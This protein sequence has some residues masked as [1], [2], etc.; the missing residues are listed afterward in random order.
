MAGRLVRSDFGLAASCHDTKVN[1]GFD[2]NGLFILLL[3]RSYLLWIVSITSITGAA[4]QS[5]DPGDR[6][7]SRKITRPA[8]GTLHFR[9]GRGLL[10]PSI[11]RQS[12]SNFNEEVPVWRQ[13]LLGHNIFQLHFAL[14]S[15]FFF[16]F[17]F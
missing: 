13:V 9:W 3:I 4:G 6:S 11:L 17:F 1:D 15:V 14:I 5:P 16:F 10:Y 2:F 7:P 12:Y 8:R